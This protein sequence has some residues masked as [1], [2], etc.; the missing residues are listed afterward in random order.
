MNPKTGAVAVAL[1]AVLSVSAC[2][3][4]K[5]SGQRCDSPVSVDVDGAKKPAKP[6]KPKAPKANSGKTGRR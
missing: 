5:S 1:C 6:A 2:S 4:G 3:P